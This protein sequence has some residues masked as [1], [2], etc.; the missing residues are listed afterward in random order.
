MGN[1]NSNGTTGSSGNRNISLSSLPLL[2]L[3]IAESL[4]TGLLAPVI[5]AERPVSKRE[6]QKF[7]RKLR[8]LLV[9]I[10]LLSI[11]LAVMNL[12]KMLNIVCMCLLLILISLV[13]GK[14]K[15]KQYQVV[16]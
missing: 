15:Y 12:N 16:V 4:S 9:G 7:S 5:T 6:Y 3:I 10:V 14:I 11:C 2:I 8:A 1:I 13:L